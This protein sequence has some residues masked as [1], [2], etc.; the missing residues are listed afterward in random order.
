MEANEKLMADQKAETEA[1][2]KE[3]NELSSK[4]TNFDKE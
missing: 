1:K 4:N 3:Y 2:L